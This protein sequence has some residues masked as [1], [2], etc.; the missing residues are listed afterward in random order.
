MKDGEFI[1]ALEDLQAQEQQQDLQAQELD[2]M[3]TGHDP[4]DCLLCIER[5]KTKALLEA[6]ERIIA[7]NGSTGGPESMVREFKN[8]ALLAVAKAKGGRTG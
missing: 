3:I 8:I 5:E 7:I 6:L 1:A 4:Q 2:H